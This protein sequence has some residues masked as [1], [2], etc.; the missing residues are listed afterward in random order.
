MIDNV[1]TALGWFHG[2]TYEYS[3]M[4]VRLKFRK[5]CAW[6]VPRE[7]KDWEKMKWMG[8]FLQHLLWY[9]DEGDVL[10]SI[11]T[12]DESRVHH[13]QPESKHASVQWKH[14]SSPSTKQF[15]VTSMPSAGK[16]MLTLFWDSHG[17]LLAHFQKFGGNVNSALYC[18]FLLKLR[19]AISRK[20]PSQL[21]RGVL[22]HHDNA[23]PHTAQSTQGRIQDLQWEL[24][25]H[26]PY[27][28]DLASS[29]FHL[30]G[31]LKAHLSGNVALMA[32]R[33]KRRCGSGWNNS[34]K[35]F[36][37]AGFNALIN[38]WDKCMNV[39]GRYVEKYM[40][41]PGLNITWFTFYIHL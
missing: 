36:Y 8:V 30:F 25:E 3:I 37:A 41:F 21:A 15:K 17:V 32:K 38:Q 35:D 13:Y 16:F 20:C 2:F 31:S 12:W 27:S 18:E 5:V 33:L 23:R 14:P 4:H 26:P 28:L 22:L 24:L 11:V 40:Y 1:A 7:L 34:W 19:D 29:D 9:A 10:N 39:D 6:W